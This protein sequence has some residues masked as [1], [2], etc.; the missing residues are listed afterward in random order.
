MPLALTIIL[1]TLSLGVSLYVLIA[2]LIV[3]HKNNKA[4]E[5]FEKDFEKVFLNDNNDK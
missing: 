4:E 2:K 3:L 5:N 1:T